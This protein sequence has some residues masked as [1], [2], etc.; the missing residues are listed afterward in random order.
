[1]ATDEVQRGKWILDSGCT[2]HMSLVKIYFS[3]YYEYDG[4]RVMMGNNAMC[5]VI[6]MGNIHLKLHDGTVRLI[7]QVRH[8]PD[9]KRNLISLGMLDQNGCSIKL[10]CGDLRILNGLT[11]IMKGTKRNE[12][13]VLDGEVVTGE[14][15]VSV[16]TNADNTRLWHLRLGHISL[17]GLKELEKQGV[18]GN[19]K[20]E[21]LDL[22][23]DYVLGKS[24]RASFK[25]SVHK[26]KSI[27]DYVHSDLWGP[28]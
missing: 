9:L 6:G 18:L 17:K 24:T 10:E 1:M 21:E 12:V 11:L 20:I 16:K 7:R 4:G 26:T 19:D 5:K 25:K 23:E 28:S 27:L 22:C 3:D 14:S 15:S 13:Y 2:F 8:V